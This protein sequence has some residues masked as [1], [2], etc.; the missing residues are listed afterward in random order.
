MI[1]GVN[2][3]GKEDNITIPADGL[4]RVQTPFEIGAHPH[5][6][7]ICLRASRKGRCLDKSD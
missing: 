3:E 4:Y 1:I 2:D 6:F 5:N 7:T